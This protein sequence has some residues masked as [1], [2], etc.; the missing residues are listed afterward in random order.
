M[1][2]FSVE[3]KGIS[4]TKCGS[5]IPLRSAAFGDNYDQIRSGGGYCPKCAKEIEKALRDAEKAQ[6]KLD[7]ATM[8][9]T[10]PDSR[11]PPDGDKAAE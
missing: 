9:Q 3:E 8:P 4:C 10:P 6:A 5:D 11:T 1:K 2:E 7:E